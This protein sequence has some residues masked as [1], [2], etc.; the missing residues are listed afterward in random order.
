MQQGDE[1]PATSSMD[2]AMLEK[3]KN[4]IEFHYDLE[5]L[6]KRQELEYLKCEIARGESILNELKQLLYYG[7]YMDMLKHLN[8]YIFFLIHSF[9]H[10]LFYPSMSM[11]SISILVL[12]LVLVHRSSHS[13]KCCFYAFHLYWGSC[14][15]CFCY[16]NYRCCCFRRLRCSF[17]RL[18]ILLF[19]GRHDTFSFT[20]P[21]EEDG[22]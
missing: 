3:V 2:D 18:S 9:V 1:D 4:I 8:M 14:S 10:S 7:K 21:P 16:Y 17:G 12:V 15:V 5:L 6:Q 11:Y 19:I 22:T 13:F 20:E